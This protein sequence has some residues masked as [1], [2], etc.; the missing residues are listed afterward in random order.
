MNEKIRE[1]LQSQE[2]EDKD[3]KIEELENKIEQIQ[4]E[5]A[6]S[7]KNFLDKSLDI[8]KE[9]SFAKQVEVLRGLIKDLRNSDNT[10]NIEQLKSDLEKTETDNEESRQTIQRL[11]GTA[12]GLS[13]VNSEAQDRIT[14][15]ESEID[16]LRQSR[17]NFL[18]GGVIAGAAMVGMASH[19]DELIIFFRRMNEKIQEGNSSELSEIKKG[20]GPWH[21]VR[22]QLKEQLDN[23]VTDEQLDQITN[24]LLR[25]TGIIKEEEEIRI[26]M[27]SE[28][29]SVE[30]K[31]NFDSN[32]KPQSIEL[33]VR[34]ND[35]GVI[36]GKILTNT[37]A[38]DELE[39]VHK[40]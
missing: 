22:R 32:N 26:T 2:T 36:R 9:N 14:R 4:T 40:K 7:Y 18:I 31:L 27:P 21:P 6:E 11:M 15:L 5:S 19:L 28:N 35:K 17:R 13:N 16:R 29:T 12:Q 25:E 24:N 20:E 38:L 1:K 10:E 37:S 3:V 33:I 30:Y 34:D 23:S 8:Q 39:Y